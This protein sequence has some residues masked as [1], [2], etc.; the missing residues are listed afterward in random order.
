MY[1]IQFPDASSIQ[2]KQIEQMIRGIFTDMN[3]PENR[4]SLEFVWGDMLDSDATLWI[5]PVSSTFGRSNV[6]NAGKN[7][8]TFISPQ[9]A[10][11]SPRISHSGPA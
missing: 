2:D 10:P 8:L 11:T 4:G 9:V 3:K 1:L 7:L 5:D 6:S